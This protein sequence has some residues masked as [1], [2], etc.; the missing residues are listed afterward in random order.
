MVAWVLRGSAA[1]GE[2]GRGP[3]WRCQRRSSLPLQSVAA[4][5][6]R[7][8][9]E[10]VAREVLRLA[11]VLKGCRTIASHFNALHGQRMTVGHDYVARV[12]KARAHELVLLKRGLRGAPVRVVPIGRAFSL[13][14]SCVEQQTVLGLLDQGSRKLLRLRGVAHK[15]T[16]TLLSH[17]CAA[18][19]DHGRPG[20]I[21]TDNEGMFTGRVWKMALKGLGIRHEQIRARSP[22]QNGR[23]E[24]LFG[25]LKPVLRKLSLPSPIELQSVLDE[26]ALFYNHVRPHQGLGGLTPQQTWRGM[27]MQDVRRHAGRGRWV[28]A[29]DGQMVGYWLQC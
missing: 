21:R 24:R 25:T 8:K 7:K 5:R 14:L 9:P 28:S 16:W 4:P 10:W 19:A 18:I 13:D 17:L 26:F 27:T 1:P 2:T 6:G 11:T 12:L 20:A 29:L 23:M 22:W 3:R 15:C